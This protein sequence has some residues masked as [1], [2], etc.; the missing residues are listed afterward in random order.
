MKGIEKRIG[1]TFTDQAYL[2]RALTHR[3]YTNENRG[4]EDN[5]TLEF[6]G[7]AVL[8]FIATK[9][10]C[11]RYP[12]KKEGQLSV[13]RA[14]LVSTEALV[15]VADTLALASCVRVS[16]GQKNTMGTKGI[17]LHADA[18]EAL[19]G[20][21]YLDGGLAV[22]EKFI[23][24]FVLSRLDTVVQ[25]D[26]W[27]EPKTQLQEIAQKK[28]GITPHYEVIETEGPAHDMVF[29]VAVFFD[30]ERIASGTGTSRQ[31]AEKNAAEKGLLKKKW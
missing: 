27:K 24:Q 3:S 12:D 9:H 16:V 14:T 28:L 21:L 6:L 25:K 23:E 10:I 26:L 2:S 18:V 20:A 22:A 29:T 17:H 30:T 31:E 19:I 7:D 15:A 13:Y 8:Q 5:E 1:Y 11:A 4:K